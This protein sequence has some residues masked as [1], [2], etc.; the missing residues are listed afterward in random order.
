MMTRCPGLINF[1]IAIYVHSDPIEA[2]SATHWDSSF[3]RE[4]RSWLIEHDL[5]KVNDQNKYE[6]TERG[7]AWIRFIYETPLPEA[8]WTLPERTP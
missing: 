4:A 8:K 1:I 2:L 6:V 7:A 3:G 5:I